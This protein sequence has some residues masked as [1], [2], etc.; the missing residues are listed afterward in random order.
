[1]NDA[2][3]YLAIQEPGDAYVLA[4]NG[5]KTGSNWLFSAASSTAATRA[6][7]SDFDFASSG[8]LASG[9]GS[10]AAQVAAASAEAAPATPETAKAGDAPAQASAAG[11]DPANA[12]LAQE[13]AI[14]G[15]RP[16]ELFLHFQI[17]QRVLSGTRF[18]APLPNEIH[19]GLAQKHKS[20]PAIIVQQIEIGQGDAAAGKRLPPE[21]LAW[22]VDDAI[23]VW[24]GVGG[25]T[26]V[27]EVLG[28]VAQM[29]SRPV[30]ILKKEY[31]DGKKIK[32]KKPASGG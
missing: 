9:S 24:G 7:A 5:R 16:M 20:D 28:Y 2:T 19:L 4:W 22:W 11:T 14:P 26:D 18:G 27:D 31:E 13:G 12:P 32:K 29:T 17:T 23:K 21:D 15:H 3:V 6:R 1:M 10:S 8:E 30:D 25:K